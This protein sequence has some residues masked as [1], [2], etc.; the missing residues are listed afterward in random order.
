MA[1][2]PTSTL[3]AVPQPKNTLIVAQGDGRLYS[4]DF[5]EYPQLDDPAL[6]NWGISVS[7]LIVGKVQHTRT[8]LQTLEEIEMEN[9]V[10]T[11]QSPGGG[12]P[13]Y[14]ITIFGATDGGAR[15]I[16]VTPTLKA[17]EDGYVW[18]ACRVTAKNF[19]IQLRGTYNINT[20]VLTYHTNG[21]R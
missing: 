18:A 6:V 9:V 4:V 20:M 14:A 12:A 3:V 17:K 8:R 5:S 10:S 21:K 15:D 16:Q 7:K 13:D 1:T 2:I 19:M 11:G